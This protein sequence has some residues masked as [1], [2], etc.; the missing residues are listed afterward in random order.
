MR[1]PDSHRAGDSA[2]RRRSRPGARAAVGGAKTMPHGSAWHGDRP[3][4]S[5]TVPRRSRPRSVSSPGST[6]PRAPGRF[7][8]G[9]VLRAV[10]ARPSHK[11]R[12]LGGIVSDTVAVPSGPVPSGPDSDSSDGVARRLGSML[13]RCG[14]ELLS[15]IPERAARLLERADGLLGGL[16]RRMA[17]LAGLWTTRADEF[18]L[19]MANLDLPKEDGFGLLEGLRQAAPEVPV[20]RINSE[21]R[22][23][24]APGR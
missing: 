12:S 8:P 11:G 9:A 14:Q 13:A 5:R 6:G 24:G 20:V 7:G 1:R 18:D 23:R 16:P 17:D 3:G 19:A 22:P 4:C 21:P 15:T 10:C 2:L